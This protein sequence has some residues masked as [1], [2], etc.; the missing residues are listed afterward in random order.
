MMKQHANPARY[1]LPPL[2]VSLFLSLAE[3]QEPP[4]PAKDSSADT[5][6]T[7]LQRALQSLPRPGEWKDDPTAAQIEQF[8]QQQAAHAGA[9]ADQARA[10]Q[11]RFP[12][13][14]RAGHARAAEWLSVQTAVRLGLTNRLAHLEKLERTRLQ[15]PRTT[16][17]ERFTIRNGAI[18]REALR[19]ESEGRAAVFAALEKGLRQLQQEF[20]NRPETLELLLLVARNSPSEKAL[21]LAREVATGAKDNEQL[22]AAAEGLIQ[23]LELIGQPLDLK[24]TAVDGRAVDL[25]QLK[26]KV[27]LVDFWATW[28]GPCLRE[29]PNVKAVYDKFHDRGFEIVGISFDRDKAALTKLV[30]REQMPW[31][32]Y[33]DGKHWDNDLGRR[34]GIQSIPTMWLVGKKGVVRDLEARQDLESKVARFLAE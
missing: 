4:A 30:A 32:Q 21:A 33:F 17:D 7:E 12:E 10:F 9:A 19:H 1:W 28:C 6:W 2:I 11:T 27:V 18:Q 24:F 20:P 34:F 25:A 23:R 15:D 29:L 22:Q 14:P 8:R 5:A 13:D 26:G 31:P 3:A 16:E